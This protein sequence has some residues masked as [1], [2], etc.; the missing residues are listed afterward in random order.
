MRARH[1]V[2]SLLSAVAACGDGAPIGDVPLRITA[3]V[4]EVPL[5]RAFALEVVRTWS[6]GRAPDWSDEA[7]APL[8][9]R[10]V[11]A[12]RRES[13]GRVEE[14]RRY[15]AYAF[16][17]ADLAQPVE[18]RVT[19]ALDPTAPGPVE[20]PVAPSSGATP[21]A[22]LLA[23]ALGAMALFLYAR[24]L[25]RPRPEPQAPTLPEAVTPG[26]HVRAL[27]R[28]ARLRVSEPQGYEET[29]AYYLEASGLVRD[30]VR[31]RFA[32]MTAVLT[33][34]ELLARSTHRDALAGVLGHCD[35]VKFA[36][37]AATAP[38]R[39][40]ML[41]RAETFLRETSA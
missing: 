12:A 14:T 29:Q 10:L 32:L 34:E 39:G 7:L 24:R 25:R 17:L 6:A 38:E 41:D 28:I 27:E 23:A 15:E 5:G 30:Y 11:E 18:L 9:V 36:R 2:L 22:A 31:E 21:W 1:L 20:L 26:P 13:E 33:T 19:R 8:H 3:A 35:A 37:H 16:S 4:R 40:R